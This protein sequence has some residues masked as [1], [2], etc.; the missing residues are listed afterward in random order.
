M[1][2]DGRCPRDVNLMQR[3]VLVVPARSVADV[4]LMETPCM[5]CY[6]PWGGCPLGS[7]IDPSFYNPGP[8]FPVTLLHVGTKYQSLPFSA[9]A[10][11]PV[12][13]CT[14][15]LPRGRYLAS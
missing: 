8:S 3:G 15:S 11:S 4:N 5:W 9:S 13:T 14:L 6:V 1:V 7:I 2:P 12:S 10:A